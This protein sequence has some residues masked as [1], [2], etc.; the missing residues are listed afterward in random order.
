MHWLISLDLDENYVA[1][2][3]YGVLSGIPR[4]YSRGAPDDSN[5]YPADGPY[6]KNRCD[7]NAISEPDNVTFIPGCKTLVIGEDTGEHQNDMIW[8]YNLESKELTR[9]QTTPYGSETTSP[10]FY[11]DINGFS[12]M[13]SVIQHPFG[14]SDS[15]ALKVPQEAR[16]YTGYIGPFPAFK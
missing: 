7:L 4:T 11:P 13:M 16:G 12:Y 8:V 10:Y 15:D 1:T 14:E 2:N 5:N 6:A 3:M 9:I